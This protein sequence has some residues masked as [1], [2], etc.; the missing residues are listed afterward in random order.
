MRDYP[1][2]LETVMEHEPARDE[3]I[4]RLANNWPEA[5]A[6]AVYSY[7][8]NSPEQCGFCETVNNTMDAMRADVAEEVA[9]M[10]AGGW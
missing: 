5:V 9:I 6:E 10:K 4:K 7:Y 2:D 1:E 3:L 8:H